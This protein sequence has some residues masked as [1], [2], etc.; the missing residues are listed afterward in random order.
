VITNR[1]H[2]LDTESG[3]IDKKKTNFPFYFFFFFY[4]LIIV[5]YNSW[6]M[7]EINKILKQQ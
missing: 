5:S 6:Q 4:R 1:V 2:V 3:G 7:T